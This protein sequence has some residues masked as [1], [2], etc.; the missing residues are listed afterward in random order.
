M[1]PL[2]LDY[3]PRHWSSYRTGTAVLIAAIV[4]SIYVLTTHAL[5]GAEIKN[6]EQQWQSSQ[7]G[8]NLENG[9]SRASPEKAE[10]LK[11]ELKRANEIVQQLAL[12]WDAL[13]NA[14]EVFD[15]NQVALLRIETDISKR[16]LTI[17]AEAKSF[18][19]MLGYVRSL[20][21]QAGLTDVYL[22]SH[23]LLVEDELRPVRFSISANWT[24]ESA[25]K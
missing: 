18:N 4:A 14:I 24:I 9:D 17:T 11:P 15:P 25:T 13:F 10:R 12:P 22:I 1:H 3:Q 7:R 23:Q 8:D 6:Q 2:Q 19:G 5:T 16:S 21:K 20:G